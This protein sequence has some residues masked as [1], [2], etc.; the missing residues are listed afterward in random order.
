MAMMTL[1]VTLFSM[2]LLL[3]LSERSEKENDGKYWEL[4]VKMNKQLEDVQKNLAD[5]KDAQSHN[6]IERTSEK[7]KEQK[8]EG[9]IRQHQVG[10]SERV[11]KRLLTK[12]GEMAG[13]GGEVCPDIENDTG[14]EPCMYT[15]VASECF[16][17]SAA[18]KQQY[19]GAGIQIKN[20]GDRATQPNCCPH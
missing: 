16:C 9:L 2:L 15:E 10:M 1:V 11:E 19:R 17:G 4:L 20:C 13:Q 12:C 5:L 18:K 7:L 14:K 6:S 8:N 3:G